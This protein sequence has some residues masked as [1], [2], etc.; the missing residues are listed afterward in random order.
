MIRWLLFWLAIFLLLEALVTGSCT[1]NISGS[2]IGLVLIFI[3]VRWIFKKLF[4]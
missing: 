2:L 4:A 3:I 1:I